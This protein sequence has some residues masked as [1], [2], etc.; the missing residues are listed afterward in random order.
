M[1]TDF[2]TGDV[3]RPNWR[4]KLTYDATLDDDAVPATQGVQAATGLMPERSVVP[5]NGRRVVPFLVRGTW[6]AYF[7]GSEYGQ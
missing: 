6:N 3:S 1:I 7:Y 2:M 4:V 5:A